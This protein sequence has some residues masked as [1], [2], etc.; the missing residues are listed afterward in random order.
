MK[1]SILMLALGACFITQSSHGAAR[2]KRKKE[3][4]EQQQIIADLKSSKS[5]VVLTALAQLGVVP[6]SDAE[7]K[8]IQRILA[9]IAQ[10]ARDPKVQRATAGAITS[11]S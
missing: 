1:K 2:N 10:N 3:P 9:R 6:F 7:Q 8:D 5:H 11:R 4:T